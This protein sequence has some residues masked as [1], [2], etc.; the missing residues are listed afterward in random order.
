M[1]RT[2]ISEIV[3][4]SLP[5]A[6]I[7]ALKAL[8]NQMCETTQQSGFKLQS[9]QRFLRRILSPD[10]PNRNLLMVHGTG[11][12]KCHGI[13]TPIL[14]HDGSIK[15]V[16]DI[17]VGDL[18]MGDDSSPRTVLSLARGRDTLYKIKSTGGSSY[19]VNSEHVLCL[20]HTSTRNEITEI[21]LRDYLK[22]S[23]KLQRDL[24]GYRVPVEFEH[25]PVDF[26]PYLL[27]VWLGDGS[28]RDPV[29]SSQESTILKYLQSFCI[30]NNAVLTYQSG[31][32]YRISAISKKFP[33]V[34]LEFLKKHDL[35]N[36]KHVPNVY[37]INSK[38]YGYKC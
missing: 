35:I 33:N 5:P 38:R 13:D 4:E 12:G 20:Q 9:Q 36:N 26:D 22:L 1:V 7:D 25:I 19:V 21:E 18:L 17:V 11:T 37:K 23:K 27:G 31:Y 14:M 15:L 30:E 32:D 29:I 24:K 8:R 2:E 16:Q 10:S 28:Q 34:F 3:N 6:S